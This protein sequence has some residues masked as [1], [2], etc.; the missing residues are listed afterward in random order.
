MAKKNDNEYFEYSIEDILKSL[1]GL[2]KEMKQLRQGI[3][4]ESKLAYTNQDLMDM[5]R[6]KQEI[7]LR[8]IWNITLMRIKQNA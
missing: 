1:S 3:I 2:K 7:I 6:K 5:F 8:H 4:H